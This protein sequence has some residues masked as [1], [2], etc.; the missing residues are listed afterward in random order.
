[1]PEFAII[2][3]SVDILGSDDIYFPT[4]QHKIAARL[5]HYPV[6][7]GKE[8]ADNYVRAANVVVLEGIVSDVEPG[9]RSGSG[10]VVWSQIES[11]AGGPLATIATHIYTYTNMA[12]V[13]SESRRADGIRDGLE[14]RAEFREVLFAT[15]AEL[16]ITPVR[17][18]P[19]GPAAQRT[20][21]VAG[22]HRLSPEQDISGSS[23][24]RFQ[25]LPSAA[26]YGP[27][28]EGSFP[29]G[30]AGGA[31]IQNGQVFPSGGD[32]VE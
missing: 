9:V 24:L 30:V 23:G 13:E 31:L 27:A 26:T 6:E 14:F 1:M 15:S 25:G 20:A 8:L 4:E 32:P 21:A 3:A 18:S 7:S 19:S 16:T 17:V 5:T 11:L 12:L 29:S 22:G 28:S 2:S 10:P